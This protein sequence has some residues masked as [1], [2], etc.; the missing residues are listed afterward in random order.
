MNVK[1]TYYQKKKKFLMINSSLK[2]EKYKYK[3]ILIF[4]FFIFYIEQKSK[5]YNFFW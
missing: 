5:I 1:P 2:N 4:S 3:M